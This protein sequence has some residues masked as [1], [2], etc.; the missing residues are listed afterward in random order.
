MEEGA[1]MRAFIAIAII[2]AAIAGAVWLYQHPWDLPFGHTPDEHHD[3]AGGGRWSASDWTVEGRWDSYGSH[4]SLTASAPPAEL[5]G[6]DLFL[7]CR[8]GRFDLSLIGDSNSQ[9]VEGLYDIDVSTDKSYG[10][11]LSLTRDDAIWSDD[12]TVPADTAEFALADAKQIVVTV[13]YRHGGYRTYTY[14]FKNLAAGKPQL[15]KV[16]TGYPQ[17]YYGNGG[18]PTPPYGGSA[19]Q[20]GGDY[21]SSEPYN[22]SY[23]TT[24]SNGG[25]SSGGGNYSGGGYDN[26]RSGG[27][28]SSGGGYDYN[29]SGGAPYATIDGYN[30]RPRNGGGYND[31]SRNGEGYND[32]PRNGK[33][34]D[35]R[36]PWHPKPRPPEKPPAPINPPRYRSL[37][38]EQDISSQHKKAVKD[39]KSE[40]AH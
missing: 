39:G 28:Y 7:R 27:N 33:S 22:N 1:G 38:Q 35:Y 15:Y 8:D 12:V 37:T 29:R 13:G 9:Y 5:Q 19:Y 24:P 18:Y 31:R 21:P 11:V 10:S 26:N 40:I 3:R 36:R 30:D 17:P 2:I 23:A 20:Q 4:Y 34:Y 25:Y 32:Y 6:P 16:C 14:N